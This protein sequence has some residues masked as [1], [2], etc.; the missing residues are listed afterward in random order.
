MTS[1]VNNTDVC[2][3]WVPPG[4]GEILPRGIVQVTV[5][6]GKNPSVAEH[7]AMANF[8]QAVKRLR[9]VRSSSAIAS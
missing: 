2:V 8:L 6:V 4:V 5:Y 1:R 9:E 7:L 3:V